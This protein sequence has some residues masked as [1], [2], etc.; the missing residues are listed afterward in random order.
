MTDLRDLY[1][2]MKVNVDGQFLEDNPNCI[3]VFGDNTIRRGKGGAAALRDYPNTYG[4]ITKKFPANNDKDFYTVE[5][6]INVYNDE[7]RKLIDALMV[8]G[9]KVFLI[10]PVGSGLA[11]RFG[12]WEQIIKPKLKE[13]L[14][15]FKNIIWLY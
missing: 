14:K 1:K 3:F 11:N 8:S 15:E 9:D 10:S 12:I 6:Y 2:E 13:D 7:L 5:E 4:F